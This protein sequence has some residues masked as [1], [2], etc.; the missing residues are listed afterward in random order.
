MVHVSFRFPEFAQG[1]WSNLRIDGAAIRYVYEYS[2]DDL[3]NDEGELEDTSADNATDG[4]AEVTT[5]ADATVRTR[6]RRQS[7]ES[8]TVTMEEAMKSIGGGSPAFPTHFDID[9]FMQDHNLTNFPITNLDM[10]TVNLYKPITTE[11]PEETVQTRGR[12]SISAHDYYWQDLRNAPKFRKIMALQSLWDTQLQADIK[13]VHEAMKSSRKSDD[14]K[15][16][17]STNPLFVKVSN[18]LRKPV[19][20]T[21]HTLQSIFGLNANYDN[22]PI[23]QPNGPT[24]P[25]SPP[26]TPPPTPPRSASDEETSIGGFVDGQA[27]NNNVSDGYFKYVHEI[28]KNRTK[29]CFWTT[30]MYTATTSTQGEFNEHNRDKTMDEIEKF[31]REHDKLHNDKLQDDNTHDNNRANGRNEIV[32]LL[33]LPPPPVTVPVKTAAN[34][35]TFYLPRPTPLML[36]FRNLLADFGYQFKP[37]RRTKREELALNSK[38][39]TSHRMRRRRQSV[40][41]KGRDDIEHE[42]SGIDG[43]EDD[44]EEDIGS[45]DYIDD[46]ERQ[47]YSESSENKLKTSTRKVSAEAQKRSTLFLAWWNAYRDI[48]MNEYSRMYGLDAKLKEVESENYPEMRPMPTVVEFLME[49]KAIGMDYDL[50]LILWRTLEREHRVWLARIEYVTLQ[51]QNDPGITLTDFDHTYTD[52]VLDFDPWNP[53]GT[54]QDPTKYR[55]YTV[56]NNGPRVWPEETRRATWERRKAQG[57]LEVLTNEQKYNRA[58]SQITPDDDYVEEEEEEVPPPSIFHQFA[59]DGPDT[60][61]RIR[62]RKRSPTVATGLQKF[63]W[64]CVQS[65]DDMDGSQLP[66]DATGAKFLTV[67]GRIYDEETPPPEPMAD[68]LQR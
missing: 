32:P 18:V 8:E 9:K 35:G 41:A 54:A 36:E 23:N 24:P 26:P 68:N 20:E 19:V 21:W 44:D 6:V 31:N 51:G 28:K 52:I 5:A 49:A 17:L 34:R 47:T 37:L 59:A 33:L 61:D 29:R 46:D 15:K 11:A 16:K 27:V 12:R 45:G 67:G 39:I 53:E 64:R 58:F 1:V 38:P 65:V 66:P 3:A 56:L 57:R 43:R 63:A 2:P 48:K 60:S 4:A 40:D 7:S 55:V 50:A 42:G 13:L 25:P 10:I 22:S 62:R 14:G 30:P